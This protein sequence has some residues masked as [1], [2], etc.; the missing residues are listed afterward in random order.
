M[1]WARPEWLTLLW[2]LPVM[3]LWRLLVGRRER[4][5]V[6]TLPLWRRVAAG[7]PR[8][9]R[10]RWRPPIEVL[11][12]VLAA[13]LMILALAGPV[14]P[15][16]RSPAPLLVVLDR[17]GSMEA[18]K[19]QAEWRR[20]LDELG[21][22]ARAEGRAL[23]VRPDSATGPA[24]AHRRA[25]PSDLARLLVPGRSGTP[26]VL[27]TDRSLPL[28][29]PESIGLR[30]VRTPLDNVGII[31]AW[32]RTEGDAPRLHV[33]LGAARA[34]GTRRPRLRVE[35]GEG[36][37][38]S[39]V[40]GPLDPRDRVH[41]VP[42][43][44]AASL[45]ARASV[46]RLSLVGEDDKAWRDDHP[47]DDTA[48]LA[49]GVQGL[50]F[51]VEPGGDAY[52]HA[53][54]ALGET[55]S[56]GRDVASS[57]PVFVVGGRRPSNAAG[58]LLLP[59]AEGGGGRLGKRVAASAD[60]LVFEGEALS[61][62]PLARLGIPEAREVLGAGVSL[63]DF[64]GKTVAMAFPERHEVVLGFDPVAAGWDAEPVFPLI[65]RAWLVRAVGRRP[66]GWSFAR[67][68]PAST[69]A[70][71]PG[72]EDR[73]WRLPSEEGEA[74]GAAPGRSL[75]RWTFAAASLVVAVLGAVF[76]PRRAS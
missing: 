51:L 16:P 64:G 36:G 4:R 26:R 5:I 12:E 19:R 31:S 24:G 60:S 22:A 68:D 42:L 23:Q 66:G 45:L 43:S 61:G 38:A 3:V 10:R 76:L 44:F 52:V 47:G 71:P 30:G 72:F 15:A 29:V 6:A 27:V 50:R 41:V 63:V 56:I 33:A 32:T 13:G 75:D 59:P 40:F 8:R 67:R 46:L 28:S 14:V 1:T 65:L 21:E 20:I 55:V 48:V 25:G 62:L 17:G 7:I 54:E 74:F 70:E 39:R 73:P 9:R 69:R 53:L 35:V 2:L 57:E 34:A 37:G 18:P 58:A 11:G 49:R